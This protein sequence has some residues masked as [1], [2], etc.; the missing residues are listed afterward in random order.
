MNSENPYAPPK[1]RVTLSS[2][3]SDPVELPGIHNYATR[4]ARLGGALIDMLVFLVVAI[5]FILI[6]EIAS[7][8]TVD[9]WLEGDSI[10]FDSIWAT[11]GMITAYLG[12]QSHFWHTRGQSIGK[13]ALRTRIVMVTG[14]R[15]T[16]SIIF[17]RRSVLTSLISYIPRLGNLFDLVDGLAIFR[18]EHNCLHDDFA[19]TRVIRVRKDDECAHKGSS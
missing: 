6:G 12:I 17:W 19:G 4:W 15:A 7:K 13:I 8:G 1:T 18:T 14:Q 2:L 5:L 9:D 16:W 3:E 11:I 10:W